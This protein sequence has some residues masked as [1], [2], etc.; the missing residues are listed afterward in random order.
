M[1]KSTFLIVIFIYATVFSGRLIAQDMPQLDTNDILHSTISSQKTYQGEGLYGYIDGGAEL[2]MAYGFD[3]LVLQEV[4]LGGEKYTIQIYRMADPQSAFG[5]YSIY[6]FNCDSS[7]RL[8]RCQ[9]A[10]RYQYIA[11]RNRYYYSIIN[12]SGSTLARQQSLD[13]GHILAGK[14]HPDSIPWPDIFNM[15]VFIGY[16]NSLKYIRSN[17]ALQQVLV[18]WSKY[19]EFIKNYSLWYLP[20]ENEISGNIYIAFINFQNTS[21]AKLFI[22]NSALKLCKSGDKILTNGKLGW[23]IGD[24]ELMFLDITRV[25]E[26][27]SP[28]ISAIYQFMNKLKKKK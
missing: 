23:L 17:I 8:T 10:T 3:K 24:K 18:E 4:E 9:C 19:F 16:Q 25:K 13:I 1:R 7:A 6:R 15:D 2:Y 27:V 12:Q 14:I 5:I 11:E 20:I 22:K 26:P 21:D 28:Y